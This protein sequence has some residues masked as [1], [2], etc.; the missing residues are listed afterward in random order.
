LV[1]ALLVDGSYPIRDGHVKAPTQPGLGLHLTDDVI[2]KYSNYRPGEG[3][4]TSR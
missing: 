2:A 3:I 4:F 1:N